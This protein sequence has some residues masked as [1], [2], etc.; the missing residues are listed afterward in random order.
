MEEKTTKRP[1]RVMVSE[2][3]LLIMAKL[4]FREGKPRPCTN[5]FKAYNG[6]AA[7]LAIIS[8]KRTC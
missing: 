3:K 5:F 2:G 1:R 7:A 8:A 6:K 4:H